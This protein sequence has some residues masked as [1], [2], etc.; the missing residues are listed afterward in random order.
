MTRDLIQK[1][2]TYAG[3]LTFVNLMVFGIVGLSATLGS[4]PQ[5]PVPEVRSEPFVVEPNLTD[6]QVAER[7]CSLLDLSLATPI[8]SAV[9]QHD[10]RNNLLLDFWH[11]NGRHR[12]TVL[13]RESRLRVEVMRNSLWSYLGTLHATT[14]AFHSGDWRMQLWADYNELAMWCF[15]VMLASG[16]A[17]WLLSR[18]RH[19]W[20]QC[21]L[22]VGCALVAALCFWTR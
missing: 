15:L 10:A 22:A 1:T 20:A 2:H 19:R 12:V 8:Q 7:V 18:P 3:L 14:A 11:A 16:V 13:E 21:S 9:I 5:D 4:R 6:R 17:L